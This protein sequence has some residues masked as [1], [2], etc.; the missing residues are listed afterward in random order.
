MACHHLDEGTALFTDHQLHNTG[1]GYKESMSP[2]PQRRRIGVAPGVFLDVETSDLA[3]ASER[4]P[5]DLGRYE[6]TQDPSDR[7]KYRTPT[8]RNIALTSPYMHNGAL[9]TLAEVVE[10]YDRGGFP[11]ALSSPL[12]RA[13]GLTDQDKQDLVIFLQSLTGSNT[14]VLVADGFAAPVGDVGVA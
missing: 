13:L 6:I 4:K 12:L 2:E 11:N 7:W 3:A 1:I 14:D 5:N 10:F 8:L 9:T